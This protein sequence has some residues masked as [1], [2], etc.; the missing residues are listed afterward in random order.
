MTATEARVHFGEVIRRVVDGDE[1][2][3]VERAG[4]PAAVVMSVPRFQ[5]LQERSGGIGSRNQGALNWLDAW[6]TGPDETEASWWE[7]FER[8]L[9][10]HPIHFGKSPA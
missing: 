10:E 1:T 8:E 4:S 7:D 6:M 2:I 3:V 9:R 5:E